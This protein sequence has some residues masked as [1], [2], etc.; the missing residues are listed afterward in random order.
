M[1]GMLYFQFLIMLE[2]GKEEYLSNSSN[3]QILISLSDFANLRQW[4]VARK[5]IFMCFSKMDIAINLFYLYRHAIHILK[6]ENQLYNPIWLFS[7]FTHKLVLKLKQNCCFQ[8]IPK[9]KFYTKLQ[10]S[11]NRLDGFLFRARRSKEETK[12]FPT[13]SGMQMGNF[14]PKNKL[15]DKVCIVYES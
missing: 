8:G 3:L 15:P 12:S 13:R 11:Q 9:E 6:A 5:N 7:S 14:F 10:F 4:Q 1:C 2:T